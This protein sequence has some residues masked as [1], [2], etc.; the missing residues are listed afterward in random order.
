M[1]NPGVDYRKRGMARRGV[2]ILTVR[3]SSSFCPALVFVCTL[4]VPKA[5]RCLLSPFYGVQVARSLA[6]FGFLA[7]GEIL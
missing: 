4:W 7:R 6:C 5:S 2:W 3:S 1:K